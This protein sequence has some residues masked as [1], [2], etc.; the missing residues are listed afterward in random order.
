MIWFTADLHLGCEKLVEYT[1]TQFANVDEHDESIIFALNRFVYKSDTLVIAGDFCKEKPGKYRHLIHCKNIHFLLGN[2]DSEAK[3]RR[4]FGGNVWTGRTYKI[5][6]EPTRK[7]Y[8]CH[9]PSAFW[10]DSHNGAYHVYGHIHHKPE[11]EAMLDRGLPGRRSMDVGVDHA[12]EL[13]GEY[14]P[15]SQW[16]VLN[17]LRFREGHDIIPENERWNKCDA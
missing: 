4:V 3:V 15:F 8:A 7:I 5:K 2:H 6:G 11:L 17:H 10:P 16:N 9:H 14:R 12:Y 13:Y 1:R